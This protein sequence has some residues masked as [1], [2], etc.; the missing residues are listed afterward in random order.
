MNWTQKCKHTVAEPIIPIFVDMHIWKTFVPLPAK[1][2]ICKKPSSAWKRQ[3][4]KLK[5]EENNGKI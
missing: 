4:K 5:G 1:D 3:Y 2:C